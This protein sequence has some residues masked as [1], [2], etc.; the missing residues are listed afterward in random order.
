MLKDSISKGSEGL[1][2]ET[3][4]KAFSKF[5]YSKGG[6]LALQPLD[7]K[8]QDIKGVRGLAP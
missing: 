2:P 8:R 7:F 6:F 3:E 5:R 4:A 1:P